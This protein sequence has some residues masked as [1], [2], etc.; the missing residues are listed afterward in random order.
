MLSEET[1]QGGSCPGGLWLGGYCPGGF[2]PGGF[3]PRTKLGRLQLMLSIID[4][5][6]GS[7]PRPAWW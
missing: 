6:D 5:H 3:C 1:C 2:C 7:L 4:S